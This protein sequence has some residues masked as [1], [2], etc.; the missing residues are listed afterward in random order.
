MWTSIALHTTPGIPQH[1]KRVVALVTVGVEM[2]VLG[3][4]Y[5][6]FTEEERHAVTHAHPRGAHFKENIIDAFT[7]GIIHKP[8]T[9]FGNVRPTCS[10]LR[11]RITIARIFAR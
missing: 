3:L 9:T 8:H 7:Q 1:L 2:D 11:T 5:D 4:A 6:E 10:S